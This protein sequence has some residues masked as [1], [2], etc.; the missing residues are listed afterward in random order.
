[1]PS[2]MRF[3]RAVSP[4]A[5]KIRRRAILFIAVPL[6]Q[7]AGCAVGPDFKKPAAPQV[8]DYTA[9]R[10]QPQRR[11]EVAGGDAQRFLK[12]NDISA[13][14]WTL[15]HSRDIDELIQQS[16][17]NNQTSRRRRRRFGSRGKTPWRNAAPSFLQLSA[18]FSA[19]R[20][21]QPADAR[22]RAQLQCLSYDLFTPQVT[23]SYMPDVFGLNRRTVES[24]AGA[25][26]ARPLPDDRRLHH[27][28]RQCR[29]H[30]D[31]GGLD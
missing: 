22:A 31:P 4:F 24:L 19:T 23:V 11:P 30:R 3:S 20:Q 25:G 27:P 16:L 18:G 21:Q 9:H 13:D 17:T 8:S 12:G 2:E 10:S 14:W 1:M 6:L 26:T 7:L 15:F 5:E 29:G 28:D